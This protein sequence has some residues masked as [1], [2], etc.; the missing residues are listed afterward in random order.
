[1]TREKTD[2]QERLNSAERKL[3]RSVGLRLTVRMNA[4]IEKLAERHGMSKSMMIRTMVLVWLDQVV[5][6]GQ[7]Q[8]DN[9][10]RAQKAFIDFKVSPDTMRRIEERAD[11][12]SLTRAAVVRMAVHNY[13]GAMQEAQ[14]RA[15]EGRRGRRWGVDPVDVPEGV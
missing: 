14:N 9:T 3:T 6:P 7:W 2:W 8:D 12:L 1:M 5:I 11:F 10:R 15:K 4:T 13:L